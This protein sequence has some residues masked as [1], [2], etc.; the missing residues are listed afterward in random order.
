MVNKT[1]NKGFITKIVE[2][3]LRS[4][5]AIILIIISMFLGMA[6]LLLTPKEEDPQIVV[7]MADVVIVAPG[8]NAA[9]INKLV[10]TPNPT[11]IEEIPG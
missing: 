3:F 8:V 10:A 6:A 9:E 5:L 4:K 1:K 11:A 2:L 7:P